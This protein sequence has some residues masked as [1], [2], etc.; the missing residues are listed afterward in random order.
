M[1]GGYVS[2]CLA[3][4]PAL[5]STLPEVVVTGTQTDTEARR[6][7]VAG[8]IIVGRKRIE[9]SGLQTVGDILKQ[10]P[11]VSISKDGR[12][13]LL[14]L[15]GYT[16][17]LVDGVSS[18]AGKSPI[19]LD[20]V[21]V[22]KIEIV[23][24][25]VA[26]FGP[27]GIAGT[28]NIVTR[29]IERKKNAQL[30]TGIS[31]AGN[32]ANS[33]LSWNYNEVEAGSPVSYNAQVSVTKRTTP[34]ESILRQTSISSKQAEQLQWLGQ[35]QNEKGHLDFSTS[36]NVVWQLNSHNKLSFSPS[37]GKMIFED[38]SVENRR[39]VS[40]K[41]MD[42]QQQI[43]TPFWAMS[44]PLRW[45][46][47]PDEKSKLELY[48]ISNRSISET[49]AL[50][51]EQVSNQI[52]TLRRN[53]QNVKMAGDFFTLEYKAGFPGGHDIKTGVR[54]SRS[55]QDL[56]YA[57]WINGFRDTT[58]DMLGLRREAIQQTGRLFA[59]DDWRLSDSLAFN[60]G[61]SG[62]QSVIDLA[63]GNYSSQTRYRLWSPSMHIA[64]KLDGDDSR[65]LRISLARSYQAPWV[66]QLTSRPQI[67]PLASCP[68]NALCTANTI[69]TADTSGNPR[70]QPERSLGLNLSYE[71]GL[72]ANSQL[73]L[74]L[75]SRQIDNKIESSIDQTNVP[76]S[77]APRYVS[78]PA[79]LGSA[80]VQ[81]IELEMQAAM[82][83]IWQN[84]PKLEIRGSVGLTHSQVNSLP[85]PDN[86]LD[87]QTP[88]RAKLGASYTFK[89]LP[90]KF[91]VS[92][93]WAPGGWVRTSTTQRIFQDRTFGLSANTTWTINQDMRLVV[94]LDNLV[95]RKS[96]Q[97][98]EYS[99]NDEL[100]HLQNDKTSHARL[101]MRL[102]IKL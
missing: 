48:W 33:N 39:W 58:L 11:A 44:L 61:L 63:E 101:G 72:G 64:K 99:N 37:A 91:N 9:E 56:E 17:I 52:T 88:W 59:Q 21:H 78:R 85:G 76:W 79:N 81:G 12:I 40:G 96:R 15:P 102:E 28:I 92:A 83:D 68:A 18:N 42:V 70:L 90:L 89:D 47:N 75:F 66:D 2:S 20:L 10:E 46:F 80:T 16:Q 19:E 67:N 82:R 50:R 27:F 45:V 6:D 98:D 5:K 25:S 26:E 13:G 95:A 30:Q 87:K 94:N 53:T 3:E 74:E 43:S 7:F 77:S 4:E 62:E 84:A 8:R 100:I 93:N 55:R 36:G 35:T 57:Y 71:H 65:Q 24:S 60:F 73:A 34:T 23:K 97:I 86:R 41:T 31:T 69:D 32:K 22:E 49:E 51:E 29:K 38:N 1:A 54:L 14:G